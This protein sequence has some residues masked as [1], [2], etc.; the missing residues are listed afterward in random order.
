MRC[1]KRFCSGWLILVAAI[2]VMAA[3]MRVLSSKEEDRLRDFSIAWISQFRIMRSDRFAVDVWRLESSVFEKDGLKRAH[4]NVVFT[5]ATTS[6]HC[7]APSVKFVGT[8]YSEAEWDWEP[9]P[10]GTSAISFRF[11]FAPCD[12]ADEEAAVHL[13]QVLD[14]DVL[15]KIRNSSEGIIDGI[16]TIEGPGGIGESRDWRLRS[17]AVHYS[18]E[19]GV[20]Y[21]IRYSRD[22][23]SR[24]WADVVFQDQK[25]RV[26]AG[27]SIS[28]S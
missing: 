18:P 24:L 5:P 2:P 19:H 17:V 25:A 8:S 3:E 1:S 13:G 14:F 20:V 6:E 28:V 21:H 12:E 22:H 27:G 23:Y 15:D 4:T 9:V 11:W 26:L 7:L 16:R 10:V